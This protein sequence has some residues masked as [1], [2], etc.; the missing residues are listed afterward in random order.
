MNQTSII[1]YKTWQI[2]IPED[3]I[4][5]LGVREGNTLLCL[6]EDDEIRLRPAGTDRPSSP[7]PPRCHLLRPHFLRKVL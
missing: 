5:R 4:T 1:I 7:P 2:N 3:F 6:L